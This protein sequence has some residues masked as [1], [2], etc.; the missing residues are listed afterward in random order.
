MVID[1]LGGIGSSLSVPA[2]GGRIK[3]L[4]DGLARAMAKY[5]AVK[6]REGLGPI[7]SGRINSLELP[8]SS[9]AIVAST[10]QE[11]PFKIK[12]CPE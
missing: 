7:L 8:E 2:K 10:D 4:A 1:Q 9:T 6:E 11:S 3:S 5:V 12:C